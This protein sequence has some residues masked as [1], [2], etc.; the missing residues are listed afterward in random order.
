MSKTKLILTGAG[1]LTC[2][3]SIGFLMQH[4][5]EPPAAT[6]SVSIV[7]APVEQS[8]L[9]IPPVERAT[10]ATAYAGS[11]PVEFADAAGSDLPIDG[12]TLTSTD[13]QAGLSR[14]VAPLL[15]PADPIVSVSGKADAPIVAPHDPAVPLL[16]CEL[17]VRAQPAEMASV[18]LAIDAPCN[19]NERLTVHHTGM[20][21]T[22]T[23]DAA[24]H[25][26]VTVP[27]L[28]EHAVFIV[29]LDSGKTGVATAEVP[30]LG[31]YDRVALQWRGDAGF[32]IH[33]REF[34]A[35]YGSEG[36]IWP[37]H[38]AASDA[39]L[40]GTMTVLGEADTLNP[41]LVQIYTFPIRTAKQTGTVALS[42]EAEVTKANC[43]RDIAAQSL[44]LR[45][46][47]RVRT[48]DLVLSMPDCSAKGDFLVLNNLVDDLKIA[49]N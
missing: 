1:T 14:I 26:A 21:F 19:C 39:R 32:Q 25:L 37:G 5:G 13:I 38:P 36:H 6:Q 47:G 45:D 49:A 24:G 23:T 20:M 46:G 31:D 11:A 12:A 4:F 15:D 44:E 10:P 41:N 16:G 33:A 8:V 35:D 27:A 28:S 40:S 29:Q 22:D 7:P 34:G 2:A 3:L 18:R 48:Q 43:G 9:D 30:T 17:S 42:V